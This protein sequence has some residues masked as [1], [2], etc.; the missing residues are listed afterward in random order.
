M[1]SFFAPCHKLLTADEAPNFKFLSYN[2]CVLTQR[3]NAV[4][5]SLQPI[6]SYSLKQCEVVK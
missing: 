1:G 2:G 5:F 6:P 3:K 4:L